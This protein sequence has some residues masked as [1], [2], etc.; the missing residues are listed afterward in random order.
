MSV[1]TWNMLSILSGLNLNLAHLLVMGSMMR[2][3]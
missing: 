3:T 1:I 2:E